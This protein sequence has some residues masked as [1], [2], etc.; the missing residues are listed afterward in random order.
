[1]QH[2]TKL[3]EGG[4]L[5]LARLIRLL[6]RKYKKTKENSNLDKLVEM[7]QGICNPNSLKLNNSLVLKT[8]ATLA[9]KL[10]N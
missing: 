10:Y 1:M 5:N 3:E 7:S 4:L 8:S 9:S 2:L 6:A